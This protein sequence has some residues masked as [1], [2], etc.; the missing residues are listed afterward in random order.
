MA[1]GNASVR[2]ATTRTYAE[3]ATPLVEALF[4]IIDAAR[5]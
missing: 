5:A 3:G 1:E 2:L 4:A